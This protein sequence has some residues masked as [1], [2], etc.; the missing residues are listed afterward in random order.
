MKEVNRVATDR[1]ANLKDS[2]FNIKDKIAIRKH[3][4]YRPTEYRE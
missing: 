3:K 1:L 2:E 4:V